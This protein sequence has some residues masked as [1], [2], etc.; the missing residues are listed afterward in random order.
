VTALGLRLVS[1]PSDRHAYNMANR[2][3][4]PLKVK[5]A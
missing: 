1:I 2:Q 3:Q 4:F 5:G